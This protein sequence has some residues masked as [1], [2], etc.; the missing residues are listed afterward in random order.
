MSSFRLS[1]F[2]RPFAACG[3]FTASSFVLRAAENSPGSEPPVTVLDKL[4]V[5]GNRSPS[6]T[7][8]NLA[9]SRADLALTPGG[10][11]VVDAESYLRGRSSTLADTFALTAGVFAQS[12]FGSDEARLSIRGSGLQRTFHGRGLRVLQDGV[13]INL[14]DGSFDMQALEPLTA[15]HIEV[16]RG[17]N[18]LATGASTLGGSINYISKTGRDDPP[19][20]A[21]LEAGSFGYLR[22]VIADGSLR[23]NLDAY[24]AFTATHQEGF[25]SHAEQENQR[26]FANG[27]WRFSP[28]V[29]TRLYVTA[30]NTHSDLPGN[31]LKSELADSP[32][33]ADPLRVSQDQQRNFRFVRVADKTSFRDGPI[34]WNL[35]LAWSYRDLDHPISPVVDQ[36][37]NDLLATFDAGYV[38]QIADHAN[39][40]RAGLS[41]SRGA[42]NAANY[43]NATGVRRALLSSAHTI[44]TGIEGFAEDQFSLG[45]GL[46]LVVGATASHQRRVNEQIFSG[47]ASYQRDYDNISPKAGLRW[48]SA[49][50][51]QVYA[52]FSGSF[53][54]PSF[55]EVGAIAA[56]N[57]SQTATFWEIG[58]RGT[59]GWARWD[60][61]IYGAR[62]K[63]EFL[64]L[65]NELGVSLGTINAAHTTHDGVEFSGEADLLGHDWIAA[66]PPSQRLVLRAA[67]TYGRFRFDDDPVYRNNTLAGFPPHLIRGELSWENSRGWYAGPSFEWVPERAPVDQANTLFA[68]AYTIAGLRIGRRIPQGISWFAEVRNIFD[69]HYA[70]T[71]GVIADAKGVDSRQFLPGDGRG[72]FGGIEYRW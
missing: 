42:T 28:Q 43:V 10:A 37:T 61:T 16:L 22:T 53:E 31:L 11:S 13:P 23:G 50:G 24:A 70:A 20:L 36:V 67:W 39:R 5:T 47:T 7:T 34:S 55:S 38:S 68:D 54:P 58:T 64:T 12:R 60:A 48:D 41:F 29:E 1:H 52:N 63:D 49:S 27:G 57:R 46:T 40:L 33:L 66:N 17:G 3:I 19:G 30:V 51:I 69:R 32:T 71:T 14:A 15:S 44:A 8:A 72:F 26:F 18:A 65:N 59:R 35:G 4:A 21:R 6:I 56:P 2:I 62:L 9:E 45:H 25:R